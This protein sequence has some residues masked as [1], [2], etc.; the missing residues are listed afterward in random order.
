MGFVSFKVGRRAGRR[1]GK[2]QRS[3]AVMLHRLPSWH[4]VAIQRSLNR[5]IKTVQ[6]KL[7]LS[8]ESLEPS[9]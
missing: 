2:P 1:A 7:E 8:P 3:A 4:A 5:A 6:L 9:V